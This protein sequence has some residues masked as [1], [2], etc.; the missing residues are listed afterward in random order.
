V[1]LSFARPFSATALAIAGLG[2]ALSPT[3]AEAAGGTQNISITGVGYT[4]KSTNPVVNQSVGG[5]KTFLV[6]ARS[7][8]PTSVTGGESVPSTAATLDLIMPS[9]LVAILHALPTVPT[10]GIATVGGSATASVLFEGVTAAGAAGS[11]SVP[12]N[13]LAAPAQ[14]LPATG[15]MTIADVAGT[16]SAFTAPT[17]PAADGSIYVELPLYFQ[18]HALLDPKVLGSIGET[19]LDCYRLQDTAAQRVIGTID[20]GAGCS[21]STCPLPAVNRSS[22][23][24]WAGGPGTTTSPTT[25][26]SP[27]ASASATAS[28]GPSGSTTPN[29]TA[30]ASNGI[31]ATADPTD[32][33]D[34][35][36][37]A[38]SE[39]VKTTEL[40]DTGSPVRPWV[41]AALGL[42]V[43]ARIALYAR[44]RLA[45]AT[46]RLPR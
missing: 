30:S 10:G 6:N 27:S 31:S 16:V 40:P 19:D 32:D 34:D 14:P 1:L 23:P 8:V 42:A 4:C 25:S 9:T 5:P 44:R 39:S 41:F 33:S 11:M 22:V 29:P 43:I 20:V 3:A 15:D 21:L 17:L 46:T 24:T 18:I 7:S 45:A 37:V 38:A 13:N 12:V 2:L 26:A 28:A 36:D 35:G